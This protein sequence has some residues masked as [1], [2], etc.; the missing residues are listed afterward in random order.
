[1][2]FEQEQL[3]R[4]IEKVDFYEF[5][6]EYLP[7]LQIR[8]KRAWDAC[9]FHQEV[10][11]SLQ[12]DLETGMF[13][14][15]GCQ[16]YGNIFTF[17]K[18]FYNITFTEAVEQL[19]EKYGVE[20]ILDEEE[21]ARKERVQS[22]YKVNEFMCEK[23]IQQ[24]HSDTN[25]WNYLTQIRGLTPKIIKE[26]RIGCGIDQIPEKESL[27]SVGLLVPK[28]NGGYYS[29]FKR[30][31]VV[32]PRFN[33]YGN[34]VSFTGRL[35]VDKDTHKYLHTTNTEIYNKSEHLFGLYQAKKYIKHF[36]SVICVEGEL[37]CIKCHQKGISNTIAISG[38]NISEQQINLLKKY[39]SNFYICVED[40]AI[41]RTDT[42][43]NTSLDKFYKNVK[44][45][46]PYA[47]VY[48]I[49]LRNE[50]G[51][52]CDADMYLTNNTRDDFK[53]LIKYAK[54]YN[55][56][57]ID[58]KLSKLDPKN[59]EEKTA[60]I[61]KIIPILANIQN[62][63][64]RKQY[65]ELVSNKMLIPENDIYRKI[66]ILSEKQEKLRVENLTWDSR[67]IYA[68]KILLSCCFSK[69]FN[70][71]KIASYIYI[72]ASEHMDKY[73]R[74]IFLNIILPYIS[75]FKTEEIDFSEMFNEL[76]YSDS[77]DEEI[78]KTITDVYLKSEQLEDF[79][80]EDAEP[81]V[82]EQIQTLK[83]YVI[84]EQKIEV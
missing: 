72:K 44:Q 6:K 21:I 51:S 31:R 83:E 45:S 75:K 7:N 81:L 28:D 17:Y 50:D 32:F 67:P 49:D 14:C 69:N 60:C 70:I 59:I 76:L 82:E 80:D 78:R 1:M 58:S 54:I 66:K 27:K 11:P 35:C 23:Y 12:V 34:I 57:L 15:W 18:E 41:L 9:V 52:K 64:D 16:K 37:D 77:I 20:L 62:Y 3:N 4:I 55:E 39:T 38:L 33:E 71:P 10:K 2:K 42:N 73:Y 36:N 40:D 24:L 8:G 29:K 43:G 65:I 53:N 25:A 46:I 63:L 22:L 47:K 68:Q 61:N 19:A 26:F 5:Y 84:T 13:K 30:D 48:I 56:F 79:D 74:S